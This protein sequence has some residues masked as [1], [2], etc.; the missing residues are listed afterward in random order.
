M[1]RQTKYALIGVFVSI[2]NCAAPGQVL[3]SD[4]GSGD[5]FDKNG[6]LA[7]T[8]E[9]FVSFGNVDQAMPFTIGGSDAL[10]TGAEIGLYH[11][12]GADSTDVLLVNSNGDVPG[13]TILASMSINNIGPNPAVLRTATPGAPV[14]LNAN[15]TY[16]I[17]LDA[18]SDADLAWCFDTTGLNGV[19]GRSGNP[20]GAWDWD[21]TEQGLALRVDGT[22]V[23]EPA[24][25]GCIAVLPLILRRRRVAS[26]AIG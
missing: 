20:P 11:S 26:P 13:S 19:A 15:T 2:L 8:G 4:L 1:L 14:S 24:F 23:P 6:G 9:N 12:D 25:V 7:V 22:L 10:F 18:H 17:V 3:F 21:P 16:W 5:S